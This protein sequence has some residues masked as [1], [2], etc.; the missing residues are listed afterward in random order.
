MAA[1][2]HSVGGREWGVL[3]CR[4]GALVLPA[5]TPIRCVPAPWRTRAQAACA[6]LPCSTL[7]ERQELRSGE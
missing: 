5:L 4:L 1:H 3:F 7:K 6:S 2:N